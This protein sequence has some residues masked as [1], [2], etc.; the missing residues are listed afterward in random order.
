MHI[1]KPIVITESFCV[2]IEERNEI[3]SVLVSDCQACVQFSQ[4]TT[5]CILLLPDNT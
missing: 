4:C 1:I 3:L 2:L 5:S